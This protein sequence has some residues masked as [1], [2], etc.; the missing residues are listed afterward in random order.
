[1]TKETMWLLLAL[2]IR[3]LLLWA[4]ISTGAIVGGGETAEASTTPS[5]TAVPATAPCASVPAPSEK[6]GSFLKKKAKALAD[7]YL[8]SLGPKTGGIIDTHDVDDAIDAMT[9]E[10][11][12]KPCVA[13]PPAPAGASQPAQ[14]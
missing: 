3:A 2:G 4:A 8:G 7:K 11:A 9:K 10:P 5:T 12:N 13:N 6:H 1:M 14:R